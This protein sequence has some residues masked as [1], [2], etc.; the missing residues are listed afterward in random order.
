MRTIG[1]L[2][3]AHC[4]AL[5]ATQP[6]GGSATVE[7]AWQ[8][9]GLRACKL[10]E[11]MRPQD[12]AACAS[13]LARGGR[14]DMRALFVL[15]EVAVARSQDFGI[16]ESGRMLDAYAALGV[17]NEVLFEALGGRLAALMGGAGA[18]AAMPQ[19]QETVDAEHA[20]EAVATAIAAHARLQF[21]ALPAVAVLGEALQGP[22]SETAGVADAARS[23]AP[24]DSRPG[25]PRAADAREAPGH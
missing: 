16:V 8:W 15:A 14:R 1:E 20:R 9:A 18:G 21:T 23:V 7:A 11:D 25:R 4:E 6:S 5:A 2:H 13:A 10:A 22:W 24:A 19:G 17:R 12:L 3:A